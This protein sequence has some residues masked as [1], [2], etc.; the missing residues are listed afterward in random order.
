MLTTNFR[1]YKKKVNINEMII[2]IYDSD[3]EDYTC[4]VSVGI[5]VVGAGASASAGAHFIIIVLKYYVF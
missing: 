5:G 1:S 4:G 3:L 2:K